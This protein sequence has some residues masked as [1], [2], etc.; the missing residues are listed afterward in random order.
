MADL[1]K[2]EVNALRKFRTAIFFPILAKGIW[3]IHLQKSLYCNPTD[4]HGNQHEQ[5]LYCYMYLLLCN[6]LVKGSMFF[7]RAF[8]LR[9]VWLDGFLPLSPVSC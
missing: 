4:T 3:C 1:T 7:A 2:L 6:W 8:A 9:E 5:L